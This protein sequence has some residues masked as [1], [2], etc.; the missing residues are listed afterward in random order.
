M[1]RPVTEWS[2]SEDPAGWDAENLGK[3]SSL[4]ALS[5][6][7][8]MSLPFTGMAPVG[9]PIDL[10]CQKRS[11]IVLALGQRGAEDKMRKD[12][13]PVPPMHLLFLKGAIREL[14]SNINIGNTDPVW[15]ALNGISV[16]E[17]LKY[18]DPFASKHAVTMYSEK[19]P[20][21][22]DSH[23]TN[24]FFDKDRMWFGEE[25]RAARLTA[26]NPSKDHDSL[27]SPTPGLSDIEI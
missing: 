5:F 7:E 27:V 13:M 24:I 1:S 15:L 20:G 14:L 26:C 25:N 10:K 4:A 12:V 18:E 17:W 19:P 23:A 16:T 3:E 11:F 6:K 2:L 22:A 8:A 9:Q 21:F